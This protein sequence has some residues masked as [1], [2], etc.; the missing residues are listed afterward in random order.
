MN[1]YNNIEIT[2]RH[3]RWEL[4]EMLFLYRCA[5]ATVA[6]INF[7]FELDPK[8]L[9]HMNSSPLLVCVLIWRRWFNPLN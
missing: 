1:S 4:L 8:S 6:Q 2:S 9:S 7:W 3:K 5:V